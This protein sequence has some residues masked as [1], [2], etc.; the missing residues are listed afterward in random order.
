MPERDASP[1][2]DG[3]NNLDTLDPLW[4]M[5][6]A[7][8]GFLAG[9]GLMHIRASATAASRAFVHS[10]SG[11]LWI[12]LIGLQTAFWA[13]AVIPLWAA[14]RRFRRDFQEEVRKSR[15]RVR[16]CAGFLLGLFFFEPRA[17]TFPNVNPLADHS[18]KTFLLTI[19]AAVALGAPAFVGMFWV[20]EIARSLMQRHGSEAVGTQYLTLRE[21]LQRFLRIAGAV[22]ALATLSTGALRQAVVAKS[23]F[24]PEVVLEYGALLCVPLLMA[25]TPAYLRLR[26]LGRDLIKRLPPMP[27]MASE[28]WVKWDEHRRALSSFLQL[29]LG[30]FEQLQASIFVLAPLLSAAIS[31]AIPA[32]PG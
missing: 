13:V 29:E 31:L 1:V 26:A 24:P 9:V 23:Q 8:G 17:A 18:W 14:L 3:S 4:A 11:K 15:L 16:V 25:Y 20:H 21:D 28:D 12:G 32:R 27:P 22:I 5:I 7:V 2:Q 6:L 30:V 19:V 10:P